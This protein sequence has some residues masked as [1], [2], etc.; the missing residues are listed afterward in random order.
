MSLAAMREELETH[1]IY[2][3]SPGMVRL[4]QYP[5]VTGLPLAVSAVFDSDA[6]RQRILDKEVEWRRLL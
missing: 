6:M 1:N 4:F 5:C 3:P 2:H